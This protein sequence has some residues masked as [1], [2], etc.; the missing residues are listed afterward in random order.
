[1]CT[2]HRSIRS[3]A[4]M[5][6]VDVL[7]LLVILSVLGATGIEAFR[8]QR[9]RT[10]SS[11]ATLNLKRIML[12]VKFYN[13]EQVAKKKLAQPFTPYPYIPF[14]PR[15]KPCFGGSPKYKADPK[16]WKR[17][18]WSKIGFSILDEHYYRY[19]VRTSN[20][21]AVSAFFVE[22][23]GDLNCNRVYS[24]YK[25]RGVVSPKTHTIQTQ[26]MILYR[27]LE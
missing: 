7:L 3:Q 15:Q 14:T 1:M 21:A 6:W 5:M 26:G 13:E 23:E 17:H 10:M 4:G 18:D 9:L 22:A 8:R 19:S 27:E 25:L 12:G 24:R 20:E 2:N 16:R 11:E